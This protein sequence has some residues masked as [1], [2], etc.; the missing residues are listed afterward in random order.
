M[1]L[2]RRRP[3]FFVFLLLLLEVVAYIV[4]YKSVL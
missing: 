2:L 1:K 4:Q 3:V